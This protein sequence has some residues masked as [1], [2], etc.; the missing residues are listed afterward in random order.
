MG[1]QLRNY[2]PCVTL[3]EEAKEVG[4]MP[5]RNSGNNENRRTPGGCESAVAGD[6][7]WLMEPYR[8]PE[9]R[10]AEGQPQ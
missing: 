7:L 5:N 9:R 6:S 4:K 1:R 3:G 2:F 8:S 10:H